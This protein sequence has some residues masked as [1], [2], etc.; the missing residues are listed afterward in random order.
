MDLPGRHPKQQ[1]GNPMRKIAM[2]GA[3]M[4]WYVLANVAFGAAY[5]L[6]VPIKKAMTDYGLVPQLT[7]AEA[8]WYY[9][10][11]V[12]F[13]AAYFAKLPAARAIGELPELVKARQAA[14]ET[15]PRIGR[16]EPAGELGR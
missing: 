6:K 1:E 5:L 4:F 3:E 16:I 7:A 11:C 8:F 10:G 9:T 2:T 15:G 12:F 14:T 13:G